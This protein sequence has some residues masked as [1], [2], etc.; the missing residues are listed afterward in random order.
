MSRRQNLV[1]FQQAL[2]HRLS[3]APARAAVNALLAVSLGAQPW[4]IK[5]TDIAEVLS[6]PPIESVPWTKPWF[7]GATNFRG[8]VYSV[9]DLAAFVGAQ[10]VVDPRGARLLLLNRS[11]ARGCALLVA[12]VLGMRNPAAFRPV[13]AASDGRSWVKSKWLDDESVSWH[14]LDLRA[15][16]AHPEFLDA[17]H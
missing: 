10:A 13:G 11:V 9:V 12:Q 8:Q 1:E 14:E 5:L 3:D 6:C 2:A 7:R 15:L 16:S 4:L 17:S